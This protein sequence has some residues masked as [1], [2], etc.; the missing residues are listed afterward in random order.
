MS[1]TEPVRVSWFTLVPALLF[2]GTGTGY[3]RRF[4]N[5]HR[6]AASRDEDTG[7]SDP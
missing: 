5:H 2:A 3:Y 6:H 7:E 4:K 1:G